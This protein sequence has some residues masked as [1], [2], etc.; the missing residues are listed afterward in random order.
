MLITKRLKIAGLAT[1]AG[2][3][4]LAGCGEDA[5]NSGGGTSGSQSVQVEVTGA[6]SSTLAKRGSIYCSKSDLGPG[7]TFELYLMAPPEGLNLVFDRDLTAGKH[8]IVGADDDDRAARASFYYRAPDR[9]RFDKV[10]SATFVVEN[11]PT[12]AGEAFVAQIDA[13]MND[14]DGA[15]IT[16]SADINVVAGSQTF[17]ECP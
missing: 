15:S 13:T 10:D 17:D 12:K 5:A 9:R 2:M 16:L 8:S 4:A 3:L 6:V 1:V 14:D 7:Y 11:M